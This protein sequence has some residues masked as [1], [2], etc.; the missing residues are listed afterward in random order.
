MSEKDYKRVKFTMYGKYN[1]YIFRKCTILKY[2]KAS[3]KEMF[4]V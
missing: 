2:V 4:S 1:K 3:E